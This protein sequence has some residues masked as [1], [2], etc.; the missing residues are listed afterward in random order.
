VKEFEKHWRE[1]SKF[2][3]NNNGKPSTW[4]RMNRKIHI[5]ELKLSSAGICCS[6]GEQKLKTLCENGG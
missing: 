5:Q 4:T 6:D 1:A 3:N 2:P